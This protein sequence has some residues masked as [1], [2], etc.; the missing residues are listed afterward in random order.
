[1]VLFLCDFRMAWEERESGILD[2]LLGDDTSD[3]L[4][5]L[6]KKLAEEVV[7]KIQGKDSGLMSTLLEWSM[8]DYLVN[9]KTITDFFHDEILL[10]N[11]WEST[12]LLKDDLRRDL[13]KYRDMLDSAKNEEDLEKL[14]KE[15]FD[16]IEKG[17]QS[18]L[19]TQASSGSSTSWWTST[20]RETRTKTSSTGFSSSDVAS[21]QKAT[22]DTRKGYEIDHFDV[23][24]SPEIRKKW[25]N[26]KWKEK[27]E[28]EPF[29]CAMKAYETEKTAWHLKNLKY[30]TVVDFT[31]NQLTQNRFFVINLDTNTVEYAEKC[32]HWV[33]S[34]G[35]EWTT[36][37]SNKKGS[38]QSSLWAFV[39]ADGSISN[40]KG[41]WK[42]NFWK[43]LEG[44]NS[45][46]RS[47]GC[48]IHPVGSLVYGTWKSTSEWCFTIPK[49]QKYV[50]EILSKIGWW[51]L[52]F[53]YA[54]SEKYFAQ[55]NYFHQT[56]NG[57]Y[58]A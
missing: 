9:E 46:L 5:E 50:N 49:S 33:N 19:S 4:L 8:V 20:Q 37:F 44:S 2:G 27:P 42:W 41:T 56:S 31:K 24:V 55:S 48:A 28:L 54:K 14:R 10:K 58:A 34:G 16:D 3:E 53:A 22:V 52:V 15:I 36:S 29:A 17:S 32:W 18:W 23:V 51:S 13:E 26:L 1:M 21:N 45:N 40:S 7:H 39:T 25:E 35:R 11:I 6:K 38:L 57:A 47:R 43:W 12:W 30:L